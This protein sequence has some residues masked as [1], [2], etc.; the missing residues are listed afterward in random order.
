MR[1]DELAAEEEIRRSRGRDKLIKTGVGLAAS[2]GTAALGVGLA[3]KVMPF[4]SEYIP[5]DLALKGI[6]KVSPQL[7]KFLDKGQKMGL[8]VKEGLDFIKQNIMPKENESLKKGESLQDFETNY[9]KVAQALANTMK[10]GQSPDAA[11]AILKNSS[12]LKS[13]IKKIEKDI[14]KNFVDYVLDL[15]GNMQQQQSQMQPEQPQQQMEQ[16]QG[17]GLDQQIMSALDRILKM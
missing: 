14:G 9:P 7:G 3:S 13:D 8:N 2:A 11:A 12:I 15:F 4:L 5:A 6:N 17:Q 1:A 16:P 10:N